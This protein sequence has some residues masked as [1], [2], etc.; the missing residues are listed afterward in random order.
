[1]SFTHQHTMS[2]AGASSTLSGVITETADSKPPYDIDLTSSETNKLVAATIDVS[3]LKSFYIL[4][5]A[6][7][8]LKT[9]SS[10]APDD[11]YTIPAGVPFRWTNT[12]SSWYPCPFSADVTALYI[13]NGVA[14]ANNVKMDF[15]EDSTV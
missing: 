10:S 5:L 1:M 12:E 2:V 15:L 11:T 9:N 14:A 13:T 8:T 7:I 3:Q 4:P 6:E